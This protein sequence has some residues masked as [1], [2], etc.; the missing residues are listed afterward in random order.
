MTMTLNHDD[1]Y[2][3]ERD[4]VARRLIDTLQEYLFLKRV[5]SDGQLRQI[6]RMLDLKRGCRRPGVD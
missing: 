6:S 2:D 3:R 5:D 1:E 4:D